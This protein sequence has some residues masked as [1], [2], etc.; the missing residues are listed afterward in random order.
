MSVALT[1]ATPR[2]R[3]MQELIADFLDGHS[4]HTTAAYTLDWESFVRFCRVA[5]RQRRRRPI[6]GVDRDRWRDETLWAFF[7]LPA[8]RANQRILQWRNEMVS[9]QQL[10]PATI[11][12]RL[13]AIRSLAR[14]ARLAGVVAW[15]IEVKDV[16]Q[17][18]LRDT[19]EP[20]VEVVAEMIRLAGEPGDAYAGRNVALLRVM[21]D[22]ALRV[23]EVVTLELADLE[24]D[25]GTV[26]VMGKG[27]GNKEL[28]T[29]PAP[30]TG[31]SLDE[32]RQFSRH[33]N[34]NTLLV[35]RDRSRNVQGQLAAL[36]ADT[37][38][39]GD[40]S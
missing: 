39:G 16:R 24:P 7:A 4:P 26:W 32:I 34:I 12:R 1:T 31:I 20:G 29:L 8:Y 13:A 27:R 21:F 37:V 36:V 22:L 35:Y 25:R 3:V 10:A 11:D 28:M 2:R 23:S 40:A 38:E 17:E 14:M 15:A 6:L 30:T 9:R 5:T 33:K 19:R 18:T